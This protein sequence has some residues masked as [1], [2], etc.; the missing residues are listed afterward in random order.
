VVLFTGPTFKP[1]EQVGSEELPCFAPG[2]EQER[3]IL[4]AIRREL[5]SL[6]VTAGYCSVACG[7]DLLFAE[8]ILARNAELHVVLPFDHVTFFRSRVDFD[9]PEMRSWR[10][11]AEQVL[12]RAAR[13]HS[14]Q[15]EPPHD[16]ELLH[17]F[18][19]PFAWGVAS[20]RAR[21]LETDVCVMTLNA[22]PLAR[23]AQQDGSEPRLIDVT[24]MGPEDAPPPT[25]MPISLPGT[26]FRERQQIQAI[27]FAD[28]AGFSKLT[29][30]QTLSF[31]TRYLQA[32]GEVLRTAPSPPE[33]K[34]MWGDGL[35][36]TFTSVVVCAEVALSL[37]EHVRGT[38]WNRLGLPIKG[39]RIGLH[40]GAVF[41]I[42][43]PLSGQHSFLGQ[44]I[45]RAARIEPVTP[46]G[47]T[48]ISEQFA[49]LL[50][51]HPGHDFLCEYVGRIELAKSYAH[52]PLYN[53][54]RRNS[55]PAH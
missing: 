11:R 49:A 9:R 10:Q 50:A 3:E 22:S 17:Q 34:T 44:Q 1:P 12:A 25:L 35:F 36:M 38:D 39:L 53:L 46:P 24:R 19:N 26:R 16:E 13:V 54:V 45:N 4:L 41:L 48:Y 29:E 43:D 32:I 55:S 14:F 31:L 47:S 37:Q 15:E 42:H 23:V 5:E 6:E 27:L 33:F 7:A 8:E 40:V 21:D 18:R 2:S 52:C 28:I 51:A 30:E 20:G